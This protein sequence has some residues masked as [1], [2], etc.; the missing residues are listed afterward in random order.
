LQLQKFSLGFKHTKVNVR[1]LFFY[2]IKCSL[3]ILYYINW[4]IFIK[5][6]FLHSLLI[7]I[8]LKLIILY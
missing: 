3:V 8:V 4:F 1:N 5:M 7:F 2:F 6:S